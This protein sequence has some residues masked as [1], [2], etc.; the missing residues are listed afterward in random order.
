MSWATQALED[1]AFRKETI[2][3]GGVEGIGYFRSLSIV[4]QIEI[5]GSMAVDLTAKVE[6]V[7]E[8][9]L[10]PKQLEAQ[11]EATIAAIIKCSFAPDE[12]G[13]RSELPLLT[14][15]SFD[16]M[17]PEEFKVLASLVSSASGV[18]AE[19]AAVAQHFPGAQG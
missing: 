1:R 19:V 8:G 10:T 18:N 11:T 6:D 14:R 16:L 17:K 7:A 13:E 3:I 12:K 4:E 9:Q 5:W 15:A 2:S